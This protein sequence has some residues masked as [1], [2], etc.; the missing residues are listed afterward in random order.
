MVLKSDGEPAIVALKNAAKYLSQDEV[1]VEEAP[2]HDHQAN[3]VIERMV[4][5]V[6]DQFKVVLNDFVTLI[7][8]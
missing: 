1:I 8:R 6:R 7:S 5:D 2:S 3:G 4:R